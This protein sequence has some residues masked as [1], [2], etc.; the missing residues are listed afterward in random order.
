MKRSKVITGGVTRVYWI[1]T[2]PFALQM[3]FTAS[4]EVQ[5]A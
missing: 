1:A 2:S 5:T 4:P 3:G